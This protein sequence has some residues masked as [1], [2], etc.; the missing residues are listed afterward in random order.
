[1]TQRLI[2]NCATGE[3]TLVD[4]TPEEEAAALANAEAQKAQEALDADAAAQKAE[5]KVAG[6]AKL[7]D[8]GLSADEIAALV[9]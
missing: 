4:Y 8:L 5:N 2:V 9:G 1:M 3:K 6:E 7:A